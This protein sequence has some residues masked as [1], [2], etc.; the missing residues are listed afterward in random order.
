MNA[1][2]TATIL[3]ELD[4]Q[5][6][7][8][9]LLA[10]FAATRDADA[11]AE[12]VRRHGPLVL[13]VCRRV[14]GH[15][16]DAE[17]AFQATFLVLA[18]KAGAVRNPELLGNYLYGVAFRVASRA[19]RSALR[20]QRREVTVAALPDP[21]APAEQSAA[22]ELRPILDQ[23]L[24]ALAECYRDA[25]ILCD[26][27][28]QSR[29]EAAA[30][31]GIPEG[32]L[33]SRLANGRK[34][35]AARL[36]RRGVS[37]SVALPLLVAEASAAVPNELVT[38][39]CGLVAHWASGG[40][41]PVALSKLASGGL[42]VRAI[43]VLGAVFAAG[44]VGAVFAAQPRD[45]TPP[46]DPPK[47]PIL[48]AKVEPAPQPKEE[49]KE[50][51]KPT[52]GFTD[53]PRMIRSFD[54]PFGLP[55]V[56]WNANGTHLALLGN[57]AGAEPKRSVRIHSVEAKGII[58]IAETHLN[59]EL[60]GVRPDGTGVVT[61]LREYQLISGAHRLTF[62]GVPEKPLPRSLFH[63]KAVEL[64]LPETHGY[65]FAADMKSFRTVAWHRGASGA[66]EAVEV[67]E[68][69]A[70]TGKAAKS[71]LKVDLGTEPAT[72]PERPGRASPKPENSRVAMSANGKRLA[73]IDRENTKVTVYDLDR[74]AKVSTAELVKAS[75]EAF[76]IETPFMTISAD[77]RRL[78]VSRGISYAQVFNA[79][80]G[81][82]TPPLEGTKQAQVHVDVN[83][84]TGDGR[85]YAAVV[86]PYRITTT[87]GSPFKKGGSQP[88]EMKSVQA[89]MTVVTVWDTQTGKAL[90]TWRSNGAWVAFNPARPLLAV[91]ERNG[92][93]QT[94][95]GFWDFAAEVKK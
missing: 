30:V 22:S 13:S 94:R 46:P 14:T 60:A 62:W 77:G 88:Q 18:K 33:S 86:T 91:L 49:A 9:K 5:L 82:V 23:E 10:R 37:L 12:L 41:V 45:G 56:R 53:R 74:G 26:L 29:E 67:L 3:R 25:I 44:A 78:V 24:T 71:L 36:A 4:R 85:L 51:D 61:A 59:E 70:T 43:L 35:L 8:A 21:P 7:D 11:F 39:T 68:V 83:G 90:K 63:D 20:R 1:A 27:R 66:V 54:V 80:T 79:D 17:D 31:L 42:N 84:F 72:T 69:D 55:S 32:T 2:H 87:P 38:K 19:R 64:E 57:E 40:S 75:G 92:D 34:K 15:P 58:P 95:V 73:V 93:H 89:E 76:Q 52:T 81:E 47:P 65:A 16:Q 48:A 6:G 50:K 28:G